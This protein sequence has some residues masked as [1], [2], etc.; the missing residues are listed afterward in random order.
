MHPDS[1]HFGPEV[2]IC[3]LQPYYMLHK[4]MGCPTMSGESFSDEL[5]KRHALVPPQLS[6]LDAA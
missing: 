4:Y 3:K 5:G 6:Q 1:M 2:P